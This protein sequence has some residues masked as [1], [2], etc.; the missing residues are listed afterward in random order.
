MSETI[1]HCNKI[2]V[3]NACDETFETFF[4][5]V[6]PKCRV[7]D[8]YLVIINKSIYEA[9]D[10]EVVGISVQRDLIFYSLKLME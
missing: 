5:N 2:Y 7:D 8:G 3:R 6:I 10:L 1:N 4:Q 9:V